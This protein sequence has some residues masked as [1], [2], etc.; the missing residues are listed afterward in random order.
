VVRRG[1]DF[2]MAELAAQACFRKAAA[3]LVDREIQDRYCWV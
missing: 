3:F 1:G 2:A